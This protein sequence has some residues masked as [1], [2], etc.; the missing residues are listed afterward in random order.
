MEVTSKWLAIWPNIARLFCGSDDPAERQIR[1]A[2]AIEQACSE[3]TCR[4]AGREN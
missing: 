1:S 4:R 3:E 2:R